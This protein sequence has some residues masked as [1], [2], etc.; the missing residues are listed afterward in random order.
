MLSSIDVARKVKKDSHVMHVT[1]I[2]HFKVCAVLQQLEI[3]ICDGCSFTMTFCRPVVATLATLPVGNEEMKF[4][5]H[6]D[7]R[8]YNLSN[9]MSSDGVSHMVRIRLIS[10]VSRVIEC[11]L[12]YMNGFY[13]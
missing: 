1:F 10:V 4:P 13:G 5:G 6:V 8:K 12:D 3:Q 7:I 11:F 9:R 2:T